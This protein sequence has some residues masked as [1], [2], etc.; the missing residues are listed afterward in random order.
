MATKMAGRLTTQDRAQIA[1][2]YEVLRW[3]ESK[4]ALRNGHNFRISNVKIRILIFTCTFLNG[5]M[6][7]QL[8]IQC[9]HRRHPPASSN[10]RGWNPQSSTCVLRG[11]PLSVTAH[12]I[13]VRIIKSYFVTCIYIYIIFIM[14]A[15]ILQNLQRL[16]N[17]YLPTNH[18]VYIWIK[19]I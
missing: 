18:P 12:T 14:I 3:L 8:K 13:D 11:L 2:R 17:A 9:R 19:T 10:D 1:A 16:F 4:Q 7:T 6:D 15:L 5:N